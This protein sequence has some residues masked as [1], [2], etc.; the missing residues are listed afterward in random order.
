MLS[1]G[2]L[3]LRRIPCPP[4]VRRFRGSPDLLVLLY[5]SSTLSGTF[6]VLLA[7]GLSNSIR[8]GRIRNT[9]YLSGYRYGLSEAL[10]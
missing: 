5:M 6:V 4:L 8:S 9:S 3:A 7:G 2:Y 1:P 10:G